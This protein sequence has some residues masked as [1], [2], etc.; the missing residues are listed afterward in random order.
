M[1]SI[2]HFETMCTCGW[3]G[4]SFS[5]VTASVPVRERTRRVFCSSEC[6]QSA[7]RKRGAQLPATCAICGKGFTY[8]K[9]GSGTHEYC[10]SVCKCM[11]MRERF[12]GAGNPAWR[13]GTSNRG[14]LVRAAIRKAKRDHSAC[15]RCGGSEN[16]QGHH[17]K[18]YSKHPELASEASNIEVICAACHAKEHPGL[19]NMISVPRVRNGKMHVCQ[20]CGSEYYRRNG[21][22]RTRFC[23][24]LCLASGE[25]GHHKQGRPR[26]RMGGG[27]TVS[28]ARSIPTQVAHAIY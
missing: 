20:W 18:P 1:R 13:G 23:S 21:I 6:Q 19:A 10:S 9:G 24:H 17:I 3:C 7:W 4:I 12:S 11:G 16:L 15:V 27:A 25:K 14:Y 8:P 26:V 2:R 22:L 5:R 28:A